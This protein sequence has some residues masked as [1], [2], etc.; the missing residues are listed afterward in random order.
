MK[1]ILAGLIIIIVSFVHVISQEINPPSLG[2][3]LG[4]KAGISV[5]E[6]PEGRQNG[7]SFNSLPEFG[8]NSFYPI[9]KSSNLGIILNIEYSTYSFIIKDFSKGTNYF[10]EASYITFN[11]NINFNGLTFGFGFGMPSSANVEGV[12]IDT[13]VINTM[14]DF[15]IGYN[16]PIFVDETGTI[17]IYFIAFYMLTNVF[18]NF[19]SDDPL[20]LIIPEIKNY[21]IT[22]VHNPRAASVSIGFKYDFNFSDTE[23]K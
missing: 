3:H 14:I 23:T 13:K 21:P 15:R 8:I 19:K 12:N 10:H 2:L 18:D 4:M 9:S 1:N 5:I 17:N 22:N 16:Y 6:T 11:P 7:I 20:K